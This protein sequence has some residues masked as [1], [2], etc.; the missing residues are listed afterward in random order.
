MLRQRA[1]TSIPPERRTAPRPRI[2]PRVMRETSATSR[3]DRTGRQPTIAST[4]CSTT[5]RSRAC[6]YWCTRERT[7][8]RRSRRE[9]PGRESAAASSSRSSRR[10]GSAVNA[11]VEAAESLQTVQP[12]GLIA[13]EPAVLGELAIGRREVWGRFGVVSSREETFRDLF[14]NEAV[15]RAVRLVLR[16]EVALDLERFFGLPQRSER[17]RDAPARDLDRRLFSFGFPCTQ[18]AAKEIERGVEFARIM[19][20][21]SHV[22]VERS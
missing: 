9:T 12:G 8:T 17:A 22:V 11:S 4:T 3:R 2:A 10:A 18:S 14:L 16:E 15:D 1:A 20:G 6:R 19:A 13:R 21:P 7:T 5:P